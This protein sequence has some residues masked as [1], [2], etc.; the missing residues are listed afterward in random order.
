MGSQHRHHPAWDQYL[1]ESTGKAFP[2]LWPRSVAS[3]PLLLSGSVWKQLIGKVASLLQAVS[4]G[5]RQRLNYSLPLQTSWLLS[6]ALS[7]RRRNPFSK[8]EKEES[9]LVPFPAAC[10]AGYWPFGRIRRVDAS[11]PL[12]LA[13][14]ASGKQHLPKLPLLTQLLF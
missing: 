2:C 13:G 12:I 11:L 10:K 6:A 14:K 7:I 4:G 9:L 3:N 1:W 5:R 8:W